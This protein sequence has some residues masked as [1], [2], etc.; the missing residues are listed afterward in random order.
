M[1]SP[2]SLCIKNK[3]AS[4]YPIHVLEAFLYK[5][6]EIYMLKSGLKE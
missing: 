3:Y 1:R 4:K 6:T 2:V 5:S